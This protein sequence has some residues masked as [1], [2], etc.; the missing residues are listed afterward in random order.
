MTD[1]YKAIESEQLKFL[2]AAKTKADMSKRK[3][4]SEFRNSLKGL[5]QQGALV[6]EEGKLYQLY[7]EK[8]PMTTPKKQT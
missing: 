3:V 7:S 6:T 5:K 8:C 4:V 2:T 1:S